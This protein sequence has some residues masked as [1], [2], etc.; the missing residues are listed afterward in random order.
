MSQKNITNTE[1]TWK[2]INTLTAS[3]NDVILPNCREKQRL[4]FSG[5][6]AD[7]QSMGEDL[8]NDLCHKLSQ[9]IIEYTNGKEYMFGIFFSSEEKDTLFHRKRS[10]PE[11]RAFLKL[12][13]IPFES[14]FYQIDSETIRHYIV[15]SIK[16]INE[17]CIN[18]C[19][20]WGTQEWGGKGRKWN[21][22]LFAILLS[23]FND[24]KHKLAA[25]SSSFL[26]QNSYASSKANL[27]PDRHF[28]NNF[29]YKILD[30]ELQIILL[31]RNIEFSY[32]Y[33]IILNFEDLKSAEKRAVIDS[34]L[35]MGIRS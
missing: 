34:C 28:I 32:F 27:F 7:S 5:Y 14:S 35:N 12:H 29:I 19:N 3:T 8:P 4:H 33:Y 20:I 26:E 16:N 30:K 24:I 18:I 25:I 6:K 23:P 13:G 2:T 17:L 22:T 10:I 1:M 15:F 21:K 11:C 31:L 9:Q